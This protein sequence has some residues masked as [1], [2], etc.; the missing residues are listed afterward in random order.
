MKHNG[1]Q[2]GV[3]MTDLFRLLTLV[4]VSFGFWLTGCGP[5]DPEPPTP[6]ISEAP[7]PER[8]VAETPADSMDVADDQPARIEESLE[9][10]TPAVA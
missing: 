8:E 7:P 3:T 2:L 1:S 9:P 4:I 6:P 10:S 5:A